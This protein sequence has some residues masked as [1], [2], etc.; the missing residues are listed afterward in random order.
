MKELEP[1]I[2]LEI[3]FMIME[4]LFATY[5]A[6]GEESIGIAISFWILGEFSVTIGASEGVLC[7]CVD[8]RAWRFILS[9]RGLA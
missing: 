1:E 9:F 2:C 4:V 7:I 5:L 6:M 8:L 3:G